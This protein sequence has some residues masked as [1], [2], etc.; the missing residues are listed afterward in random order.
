MWRHRA[1][2]SRRLPRSISARGRNVPWT[3]T[4]P[5]KQL[6]RRW[7]DGC[8]DTTTARFEELGLRGACRGSARRHPKQGRSFDDIDRHRV[9][10]CCRKRQKRGWVELRLGLLG[11]RNLRNLLRPFLEEKPPVRGM[12]GMRCR[13]PRLSHGAARVGT[14][15]A[16]VTDASLRH[17]NCDRRW[18]RNL[19]FR[20][21]NAPIQGAEARAGR[22]LGK[23]L[24][25]SRLASWHR[26]RS[27][28]VGARH[29]LEP[30]VPA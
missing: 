26:G 28:A 2:G 15:P 9:A 6:L 24:K 7:Q 25:C 10:G 18:G 16:A 12:G 30:D 11:A 8:Q 22:V 19:F 27:V 3:R 20:I 4:I 23:S 14:L 21:S 13:A 5:W 17:Q 29:R 1:A